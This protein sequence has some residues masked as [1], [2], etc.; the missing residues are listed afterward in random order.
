MAIGTPGQSFKK[1]DKLK[2]AFISGD[3]IDKQRDGSK[4]RLAA[5]FLRDNNYPAAVKIGKQKKT[6]FFFEVTADQFEASFKLGPKPGLG[7]DLPI[8]ITGLK[9]NGCIAVYSSQRKWFRFVGTALKDN[10]VYLQENIDSENDIWVGNIFLADQDSLKLTLVMDGQKAGA[11]PFLEIHNPTNSEI[12]A[13]IRS[14]KNTP[15]FGGRAF[16][17]TVPAGDSIRYTLR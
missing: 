10:A 7:I 15:V 3:F 12:K 8:R 11:L 2:Y 4:I 17:V 13:K 14:P 1:S 16:T 6:A 5:E 9:N